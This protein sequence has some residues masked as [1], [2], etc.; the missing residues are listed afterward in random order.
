MGAD[1]LIWLKLAGHTISVRVGGARRY[2]VGAKVRLGFDM[3]MA[4][5]F[6]AQTE[7][8]I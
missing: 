1:N 8:R 4:S 3:T 6:D 5:L 7:E 2:A